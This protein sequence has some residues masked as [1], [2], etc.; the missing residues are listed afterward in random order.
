MRLLPR[1]TARRR[2]AHLYG[3]PLAPT[4]SRASENIQSQTQLH[5]VQTA[6]S[7]GPLLGDIDGH[8][9]VLVEHPFDSSIKRMSTVWKFIP[10]DVKSDPID[11]DLIVCKLCLVSHQ[12]AD[13]QSTAH[14]P[15]CFLHHLFV[16]I[17]VTNLFDRR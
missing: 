13:D 6:Q 11:Y 8:Y 15:S 17:S 3:E 2:P 16:A 14:T 10:E 12:T 9:E 4:I 5:G 1:T 7:D